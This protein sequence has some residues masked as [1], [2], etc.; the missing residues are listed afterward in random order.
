[1]KLIIVGLLVL[2]MASC[3]LGTFA[4]WSAEVTYQK[5]DTVFLDRLEFVSLQDSNLGH[6]PFTS[7]LWWR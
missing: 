2:A 4:K 1:M 7:P 5:G 3:T 6:E